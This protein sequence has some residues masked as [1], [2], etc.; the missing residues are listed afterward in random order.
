MGIILDIFSLSGKTPDDKDRLII[1]SSGSEMR[2]S[3]FL[4]IETGMLSASGD[5]PSLK[6]LIFYCFEFL[7]GYMIEA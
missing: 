3:V 5:L 4:I 7:G 2:S 6:L 1:D